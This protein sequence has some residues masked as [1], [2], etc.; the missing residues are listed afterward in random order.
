[1]RACVVGP[2]P[3]FLSGMSYFTWKLSSSIDATPVLFRDMMPWFLFPGKYHV[4]TKLH[5]NKCERRNAQEKIFYRPD[6]PFVDWWNVATWIKSLRVINN[7]DVVVLEWWSSTVAHLYAFI[8]AFCKPRIVI[9]VHETLDPLE[10]KNVL[11]RLYARVMRKYIFSK[12]DHIVVHSHQDFDLFNV[13]IDS[14][15]ISI[16]PHGLYD[17]YK[18]WE[19]VRFKNEFCVLSFGLIRDYKGVMFAIEGFKLAHLPESC[20]F[21]VGEQWDP[22]PYTTDKEK[23]IYVINKYVDDDFIEIIFS[24]ADVVV[25]PYLRASSSGVSNIAMAYGIPIIATKVGGLGELDDY[26][27]M[28]YISDHSPETIARELKSIYWHYGKERYK[29]FKV[30]ERL[31]WRTVGRQWQ[32]TLESLVKNPDSS[33]T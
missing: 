23:K 17:Q 8:V 25:L 2:G 31:K 19:D 15:K 3:K 20:L 7:H 12:A 11:I 16:I 30:P 14:K 1:M 4:N 18:R 5:P 22:I 6:T 24:Y 26:P 28:F 9:D 10:N 27:G 21:V 13:S 32:K 33:G 29:Q